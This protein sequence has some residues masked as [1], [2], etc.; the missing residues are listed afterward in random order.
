MEIHDQLGQELTANKLGLFYIKQ[1][2][3]KKDGIESK[4]PFVRDKVEDLI[5][6]STNTIITV[7]R[8]A[9]QLR[10]V[11]LD[12]LGLESAIEWMVKNYNEGSEIKWSFRSEISDLLLKKEF[13]STIFRI[14]QETTTN[15][16]RHSKAKN[17]EISIK[18]DKNLLIVSV[19]DDGVGF[20]PEKEK[21]KSKLGLFGIDER[22]KH[23]KGNLKINS[24][25]GKGSEV[26]ID[27]PIAFV[28]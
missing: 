15:T 26:I 27:F 13:I 6:L 3:N 10:P 23:W 2:L 8:I 7:R 18:K 24:K 25:I 9:H 14:I 21:T 4:L 12:D 17:C 22:A 5:E 1:Q 11:I 16:I 19:K 28:S 20:D